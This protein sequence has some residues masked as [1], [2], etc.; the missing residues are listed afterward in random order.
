MGFQ[1]GVPKSSVLSKFVG[2]PQQSN[3]VEEAGTDHYPGGAVPPSKDES[4]NRDRY[5]ADERI[6]KEYLPFVR[7]K[8]I[9]FS[10]DDDICDHV[11]QQKP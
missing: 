11:K 3:P 9:G 5:G 6:D 4:A 10:K 2:R 8:I 7:T 1:G